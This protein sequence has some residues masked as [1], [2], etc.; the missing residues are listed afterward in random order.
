MKTVCFGEIMLRLSPP[1]FERL[2]PVAGAAGDVRRRRSQRGG[3]PGAVRPRQPLRDARAGH[4]VGDAA[5]KALRAEGVRLDHVVRGGERLGIYFAETGASQRASAVI[6][7]R[8][9][10]AISEM[11]PGSVPWA[12]VFAG[13]AWFHCTGITPALGPRRRPAR[14]RRSRPRVPPACRSAST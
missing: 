9:H 5:L 4:A 7:D 13:A 12:R 11:A 6:Y 1:G 3:E 2:L 8:A 14:A 10:S